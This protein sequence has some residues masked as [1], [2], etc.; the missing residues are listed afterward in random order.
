MRV[1]FD[2]NLYISVLLNPQPSSLSSALVRRAL[3]GVFTLLLPEGVVTEMGST[4]ARKPYLNQRINAVDARH[5]LSQIEAAA[6]IIDISSMRIERIRP[7][8]E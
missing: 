4:I 2:T 7:R 3:A 5:L 1:L 8:P 6:E